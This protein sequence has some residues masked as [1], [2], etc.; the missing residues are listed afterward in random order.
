M[1]MLSRFRTAVLFLAA[2][3]SWAAGSPD[4]LLARVEK[5]EKSVQTLSFSFTQTTVL[6]ITEEEQVVGGKAYFRRPDS[7]RVEH[8]SPKPLTA[9]SD[10]KTIWI[11]NPAR[12][13]V[14]TDEWKNWSN[15]AGFPKGL[16]PFQERSGDLRKKYN[17]KLEGADVLVFTPKD[18]GSWPY[19]LRVWVDP[20]GFPRRTE[21]ESDSL[22][23]ST[24]VRDLASN[25][26]LAED[27]F[28]FKTPAGADVFGPTP[29]K[30]AVQ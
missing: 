13:Q 14:L 11:H 24:E 12:N 26:V 28:H 9:V 7:F 19:T 2:G 1:T 23:T 3:S 30:G 6:K 21:L 17:V 20:A 27:L 16:M 18:P 29:S 10:G 5:A 25:P 8:L 22:K 15:S 4:A